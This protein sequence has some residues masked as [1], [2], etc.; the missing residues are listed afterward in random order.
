MNVT[1][2]LL[3]LVHYFRLQCVLG[4]VLCGS[5]KTRDMRALQRGQGLP[6]LCECVTVLY[7]QSNVLPVV[8]GWPLK[9]ISHMSDLTLF[10]AI[11]RHANLT[12]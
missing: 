3:V 4:S 12:D 5:R 11:L 1:I 8:V 10:D 2:P 6:R 7:I 9:L